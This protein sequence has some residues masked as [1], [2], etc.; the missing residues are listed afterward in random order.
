MDRQD[1]KNIIGVLCCCLLLGSC[2]KDKPGKPPAT[3][4][5]D[6]S[7]NVLVSCEGSLGNGNA[8]LSIYF[9]LKDSVY[10]D[11]YTAAN[12]KPMG[13]IFQS[14]T[15]IGSRYFF[16][17]NNS[18][19]ILVLNPDNWLQSG[20]IALPKPRYILPLD[21]NKAYVS[22]LFSNRIYVINTA[23]LAVEK[24]FTLPYKNAESM[25][26]SGDAAWCC[27]WD[28]AS[29]CIYR[30]NI[31]TDAIEDSIVLSGRAPQSI[32]TDKEGK[33][34][35]LGGNITQGKTTTLHR[36][37]P[38]SRHILKTYTF[39]K[40]IEAIKPVFNR[41]K[42][43]LYFIEVN[44]EGGPVNNGIFR[45]RID[46]E[47]L[48]SAPFIPCGPYQYFWALGTDPVTGHIYVGDPKGFVQNGRVMIYRPDGSL[49]GQFTTGLG[50][51]SF[52][53]N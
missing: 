25:L 13:D 40:G 18:D 38:A 17:I 35:V 49:Q 44:Y 12:G 9:P 42:D 51:G 53:F 19:V 39:G 7:R 3:V 24:Q 20:T 15:R 21:H 37:D 36:I 10:Q 47:T 50:P 14:I 32:L 46:E 48:P 52:Y 43:T 28:T 23:S 34:W 31:H 6:S 2:T 4:P 29:N 27:G 5:A 26:R 30:V 41:A 33:F 16:C 1:L 11:V 45:M 22:T 8:S